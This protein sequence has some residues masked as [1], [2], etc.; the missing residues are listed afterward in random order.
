VNKADDEEEEIVLIIDTL[1]GLDSYPINERPDILAKSV[2]KIEDF[3]EVS[4]PDELGMIIKE[5]DGSFSY[6]TTPLYAIRKNGKDEDS[7]I[8]E[9]IKDVM[10]GKEKPQEVHITG[11]DKIEI[12]MQQ[13]CSR[14]YLAVKKKDKV[15]LFTLTGEPLGDFKKIPTGPKNYWDPPLTDE[16]IKMLWD[17]Y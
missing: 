11:A 4:G 9:Y 5:K 14:E 3:V 15:A 2:L 10:L 13:G 12:R 7:A 6:V 17:A 8:D 1:E 16:Q